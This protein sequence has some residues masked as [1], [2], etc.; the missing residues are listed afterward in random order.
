MQG[1]MVLADSS[2]DFSNQQGFRGWRYRYDAGA[3]SP[4]YDMPYYLPAALPAGNAVWCVDPTFG[5]GGTYCAV[6]EVFMHTATASACTTTGR[7]LRPR[8]LWS[9]S[10]PVPGR[11]S[12]SGRFTSHDGMRSRITL[13]VDG[14]VA[15]EQISSGTTT[16]INDW[17]RVAASIPVTNC[18]TIELLEDPEDA[19]CHAD[20]TLCL[21]QVIVEDCNHDGIPDSCA[22]RVPQD[23]PTI[24][25][26]I[27][28]VPTGEHKVVDVAA[29]TYHERFALQGKDVIV[30]GAANNA[31]ILDGTGLTASI[32]RFTGGEPATAG[33]ENL[34]FRHGTAGS[35]IYPGAPFDVGGAIYGSSSSAFVRGCRFE[36]C[37]ADFGGAMYLIYS[38]S[39]VENCVFESNTAINEGGGLFLYESTSHVRNCSFTNNVTSVKGPGAG[40]GFKAVGARATGESVELSGCTFSGNRGLLTASAIEYYENLQSNPGVLRISGCTV[41]GN[42]SGLSVPDGAAGLRVLGRNSSCVISDGTAICSNAPRNTSGPFLIEGAAS[43][44]GCFADI[45]GDGVVNGGDLG[46]LLGAWG[47]AQPSGV[48]DVNHDGDV[49]GADLAVVLSNWGACPN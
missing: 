15:F 27:D 36:A 25:S 32:A 39:S 17:E 2:A 1:W 11:V 7:L 34:V 44:C 43:V 10:T 20:G 3:D 5:P 19:S 13:L 40:S 38:R 41:T 48:G 23:Y 14:V 42:V 28:A 49:N 37:S 12:L 47:T 30:R 18:H 8:R 29:G 26:A 46:A 22:L 24:Q 33:V 4:A 9:S 21:V 31:T 6:G 35:L 16:D 45:T